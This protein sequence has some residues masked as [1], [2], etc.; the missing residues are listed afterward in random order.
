MK[1]LYKSNYCISKQLWSL[2]TLQPLTAFAIAVARS[3]KTSVLDDEPGG[4]HCGFVYYSVDSLLRFIEFLHVNQFGYN[5]CTMLV[6]ACGYSQS[7]DYS[8]NRYSNLC[9]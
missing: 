4:H 5:A 6:C 9:A 2:H 8:C 3:R 1:C 7:T